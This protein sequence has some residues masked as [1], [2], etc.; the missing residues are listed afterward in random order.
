MSE[1]PAEQTPTEGVAEPEAPAQEIDWKS[2][3]RKWEER[4]KENAKAAEKV[5]SLEA[6]VEELRKELEAARGALSGKDQELVRWRVIAEHGIPKDY[7]EFVQ[8]QDEDALKAS[9]E[10]VASLFA[11]AAQEQK[12]A[13]L[14]V[15]AES[16]T[17]AALNSSALEEA[18]RRAVGAE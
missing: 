17:P 14:I 2:H 18:L 1:A 4:A 11:A 7:Q 6:S 8:G 15:P 9:A 16:K 3:A 10:K 5:A 13:P 12:A